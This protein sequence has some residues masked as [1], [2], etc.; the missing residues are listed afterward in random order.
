MSRSGL[1]GRQECYRKRVAGMSNRCWVSGKKAKAVVWRISL[2]LTHISCSLV[3]V[4]LGQHVF[5]ANRTGPQILPLFGKAWHAMPAALMTMWGSFLSLH[6]APSDSCEPRNQ[7]ICAA[8]YDNTVS[9]QYHYTSL[10]TC[11][12]VQRSNNSSPRSP[13]SL[14]L[15]P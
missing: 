2:A 5:C 4:V 9:K 12:D 8:T 7:G 13:C 3:N 1:R 10:H 15:A 14:C 6:G 11:A